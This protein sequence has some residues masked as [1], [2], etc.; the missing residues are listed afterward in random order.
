MGPSLEEDPLCFRV[1]QVLTTKCMYSYWL[2]CKSLGNLMLINNFD[3]VAKT[4]DQIHSELGGNVP[5]VGLD[6]VCSNGHGPVIFRFL[7]NFL[8]K[9]FKKSS[10]KLICELL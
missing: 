6:Y 9:S 8:A 7:M 10:P 1:V 3:L 5:W 4:Y 2:L